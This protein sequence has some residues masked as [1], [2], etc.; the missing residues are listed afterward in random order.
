MSTYGATLSFLRRQNIDVQTSEY[1]PGVK[2]GERVDGVLNQDVQR[3]SFPDEHFDLV[4]SNQVFEH[5]E[6]DIEGYRE[7]FRVLKN[8][9]ALI[10]S[11]PLH[12]LPK[13]RQLAYHVED[14]LVYLTPP[15]YHSS[16]LSGPNSVLTYWHHSIHDI[17]A[18]VASVGFE[19]S[20]VEYVLE[21]GARASQ[22]GLRR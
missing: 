11:V 1:F 9:G 17:C 6:D 2:S 12:D 15:E 20:L 8:Q 10:F 3:T 22:G 7:C 19:V 18:R 14:R 4:T 13:T 5:V 16:R 21:G